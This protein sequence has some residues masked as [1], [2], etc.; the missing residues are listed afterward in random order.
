MKHILNIIKIT[1]LSLFV[2]INYSCSQDREIEATADAIVPSVENLKVELVGDIAKLTWNNP[3]YAGNVTTILK[4]NSGVELLDFEKSSYEFEIRE[5]NVE[6]LFTLKFKDNDTGNF[7][8]GETVSLTREGP[9]PVLNFAGTQEETNVILTWGIQDTNIT[10][11]KLT[12]DGSEVIDLPSNAATYTLSN[13]ELKEYSFKINTINS[14]NQE[15]PSRNLIFKVGKTKIGYLGVAADL[16]SISDDDEIASAAWLFENYPDAEYISFADIENGKDLSDFRVLW[17]HYDKDDGNPELPTEALS[18]NVV[19][20]ITNFHANGGGL[21]LN[22]FAIE[23]LWTI[24]RINNEFF[25][26]KEAGAGFENGDTWSIGI[27]IGLMHDESTH[28]VYQGIE[29][30][31]PDERKMIRLIGPGY[32]ENHNFVLWKFGDWY[33]L[34]NNDEQIY[35]N[36]FNNEKIRHLGNWDGEREYWMMANFEAMPNNEFKGTAIAIGIGAFEWNQNS[37]KNLFQDNIEGITKN[38]LEYLK[39]K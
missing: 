11:I 35:S 7:S 30:I 29:T 24:G 21:L 25:K 17:W 16:T 27:N 14:Q 34:P 12:I 23:Y 2:I 28:P 20:A 39:T 26:L 22:T 9:K 15:S 8:L 32:R 4:H 3:S 6:Y 36:L 10:G 37:G 33:Q 1:I 31:S 38:A 19:S 13:A 5:V 18:S